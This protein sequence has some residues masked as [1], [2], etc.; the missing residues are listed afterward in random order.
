MAKPTQ[1]AADKAGI[2]LIAQAT[3]EG[4]FMVQFGSILLGMGT[5][6]PNG[7]VTAPKGS[8]FIEIGSTEMWMNTDGSTTWAQVG[9]QS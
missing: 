6:T 1:T 7:E 5:G 8:V 9:L 4:V 3:T 2:S